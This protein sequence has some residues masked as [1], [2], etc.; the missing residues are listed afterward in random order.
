LS[1]ILRQ[2]EDLSWDDFAEQGKHQW[3]FDDDDFDTRYSIRKVDNSIEASIK[4]KLTS[5][6][7]E[8]AIDNFLV[9]V[10]AY[11]KRRRIADRQS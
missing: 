11:R 6:P 7:S 1:K 10:N 3:V 9:A 4:D 2:Q 8:E 5:D